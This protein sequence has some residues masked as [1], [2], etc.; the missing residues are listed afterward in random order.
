MK[1]CPDDKCCPSPEM[2]ALSP[3]E[4]L[5]GAK[6]PTLGDYFKHRPNTLSHFIRDWPQDLRPMMKG[7]CRQRSGALEICKART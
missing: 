5:H 4:K 2:R 7:R 1:N 3:I 6:T